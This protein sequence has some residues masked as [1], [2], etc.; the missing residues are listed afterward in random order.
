SQLDEAGPGTDLDADG[1]APSAGHQVAADRVDF[2]S[3]ITNIEV[4]A[5]S[6]D[7]VLYGGARVSDIRTV[8]LL[9]Y[10]QRFVLIVFVG[11]LADDL[12]Y[13]VFNRSETVRAPVFVHHE[14]QMDARGLHARQKIDY[15]H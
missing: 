4:V 2:F 11:D 8:R 7:H 14:R 5:D 15:T 9:R 6:A 13:N 1:R 3:G 10:R 12:F